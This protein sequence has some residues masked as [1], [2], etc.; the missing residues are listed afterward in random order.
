MR[1]IKFRVTQFVRGFLIME[2]HIRE[3]HCQALAASSYL[4]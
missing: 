2:F 3:F 1:T 4:I